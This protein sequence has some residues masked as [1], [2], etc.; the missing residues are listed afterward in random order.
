VTKRAPIAALITVLALAA[1]GCGTSSNPNTDLYRIPNISAQTLMRELQQPTSRGPNGDPVLAGPQRL[2]LGGIEYTT[3]GSD[4]LRS[5]LD[6]APVKQAA[7][8]QA[9]RN[10]AIA[11][12]GSA[13]AIDNKLK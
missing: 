13:T 11:F 7:Y 8:E 12:P 6:T 9:G 10:L 4:A 5:W 3:Q 1:G 2:S